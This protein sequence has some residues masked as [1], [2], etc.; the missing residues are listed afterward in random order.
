LFGLA[1]V[2]ALATFCGAVRAEELPVVAI[3]FKDGAIIPARVEAPAGKAFRLE[4]I[5]R[6]AAA[7]EF[8]SKELKR[9]KIVAAGGKIILNFS[10][11]KPGDYAFFDDF[12]PEAAGVLVAK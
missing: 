5:N 9:E 2:L 4:V 10:A 12:H 7:S 1:G 3:A 6:G 8:E 11:L